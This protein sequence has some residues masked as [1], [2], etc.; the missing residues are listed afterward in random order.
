MKKLQSIARLPLPGREFVHNVGLA[1][2]KTTEKSLM[3]V[4]MRRG[5]RYDFLMLMF[6]RL[7]NNSLHHVLS[8]PSQAKSR[9][10]PYNMTAS[11]ANL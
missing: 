4:I 3:R 1:T 7:T 5:P 8:Y 6:L 11:R 2:M 9:W 10:L